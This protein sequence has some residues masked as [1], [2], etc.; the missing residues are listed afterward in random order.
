MPAVTRDCVVW[1][2]KAREVRRLYV[3][4]TIRLRTTRA[5]QQGRAKMVAS[6]RL[7]Q[8]PEL[9]WNMLKTLSLAPSS[10]SI[11]KVFPSEENSVEMVISAQVSISFCNF[12]GGI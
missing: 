8:I 1:G 11:A 7:S 6:R 10:V 2:T 3:T 5:C 12:R 9:T 4:R